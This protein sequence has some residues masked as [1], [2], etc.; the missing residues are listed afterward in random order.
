MQSLGYQEKVK[1]LTRENRILTET[2]NRKNQEIEHLSYYTQT[3]A[4]DILNLS[5]LVQNQSEEIAA[6]REEVSRLREIIEGLEDEINNLLNVVQQREDEMEAKRI[7]HTEQLK[8][9][10]YL[11][12]KLMMHVMKCLLQ[13]HSPAKTL[14]LLNSI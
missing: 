12:K 6:Y 3:Q 14:L 2:L 4:E 7:I 13:S 10:V 8:V 5:N 9:M 1:E 11:V